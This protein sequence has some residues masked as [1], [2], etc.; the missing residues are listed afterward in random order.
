MA[1]QLSSTEVN[2]AVTLREEEHSQLYVAKQL[3]VVQ[4]TAWQLSKRYRKTGTVQGTGTGPK[5]K[6]TAGDE[7][8]LRLQALRNRTHIARNLQKH[9]VKT[10]GT[11]ISDQTLC[12]R[13]REAELTARRSAKLPKLTREHR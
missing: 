8:F 2:R 7:R 12:N 10:R 1:Q 11:R 5:S 3:G 4:E 9:L 13:L 6:T